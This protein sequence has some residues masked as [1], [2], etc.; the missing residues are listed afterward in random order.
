MR[1]LSAWVWACCVRVDFS[2][3]LFDFGFEGF[4]FGLFATEGHF[5]VFWC[6]FGF[7]FRANDGI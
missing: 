6:F 7:V 1:L 2:L 3:Q 4:E 5:F